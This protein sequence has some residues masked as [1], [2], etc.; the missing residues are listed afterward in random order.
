MPWLSYLQDYQ[1]DRILWVDAICIN[2]DDQGEKNKQIPLIRTIYAASCV[3]VWLGEA[4]EDSD[5]ALESIRH[6]AEDK[7]R[8]GRPTR[9][10]DLKIN[11]TACLALL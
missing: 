1:L 10:Q 6:L 4:M 5:G 3:I 2:Q 9:A 11:Y 7:T 8:K